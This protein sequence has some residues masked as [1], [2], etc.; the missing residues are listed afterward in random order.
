MNSCSHGTCWSETITKGKSSYEVKL[1]SITFHIYLPYPLN[2]T[3]LVCEP[4]IEK[5]DNFACLHI[6]ICNKKMI[7]R[8]EYIQNIPPSL[9][10][11]SFP[12]AIYPTPIQHIGP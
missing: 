5:N 10:I 6:E 8:N 9:K 2:C 12:E 11:L 7:P 3:D 1:P 4:V